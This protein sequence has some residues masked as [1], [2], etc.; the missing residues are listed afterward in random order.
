MR[1]LI[2]IVYPH[3]CF[4]DLNYVYLN[5]QGGSQSSAVRARFFLYSA[6]RKIVKDLKC[7]YQYRNSLRK[8]ACLD[9]I[10]VWAE[11]NIKMDLKKQVGG[12]EWIDL[13]QDRYK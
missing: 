10:G 5:L 12:V 9:D 3:T 13:A 2:L 6:F 11:D 7:L 8:T 1:H 4:Y